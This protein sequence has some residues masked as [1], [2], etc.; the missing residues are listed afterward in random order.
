MREGVFMPDNHR[1]K[2]IENSQRWIAEWTAIAHER[3]ELLAIQEM[4][5]A[6]ITVRDEKLD[7]LRAEVERLRA[8]LERIA[9]DSLSP[10]DDAIEALARPKCP[11]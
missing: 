7:E 1:D 3:D 6:E 11:L 4:R 5:D 2:L 10:R 9:D 8:V